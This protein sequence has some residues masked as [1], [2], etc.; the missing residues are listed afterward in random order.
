[1]QAVHAR[2][3]GI[4]YAS[5]LGYNGAM[6][7]SQIDPAADSLVMLYIPCGSEDEAA[8]L[9]R[10]LLDRNLIACGN[11][12]ASRS[13]YKWNGEIVDGGE[14]LLVAKTTQAQAEAAAHAAEALHSYEVPCVIRLDVANVNRAYHLW[15][16]GHVGTN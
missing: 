15:V 8:G 2:A 6:N 13:I 1:Y 7:V 12:V 11:V 4:G 9:A 10:A 16:Q 5:R 14:F 3:C